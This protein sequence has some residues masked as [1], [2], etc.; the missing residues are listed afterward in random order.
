MWVRDGAILNVNQSTD[1]TMAGTIFGFG[2]GDD[3]GKLRKTG[4]GTLTTS[5]SN[6]ITVEN[7]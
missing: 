7:F 2:A 4:S 1:T 6:N 5:G 3:K